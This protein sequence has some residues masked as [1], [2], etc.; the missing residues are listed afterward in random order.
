[1]KQNHK[2]I[3]KNTVMLYIRILCAM[4][5]S[6]YISRIVLQLLGVEDF[7][8]LSAVFGV[9]NLMMFVNVSLSGATSRF[10]TFELGK[11]AGGNLTKVFRSALF[12]HVIAAV[13][14]I[15]LVET[16]GLW[17]VNHKLVLGPGKLAAA[18]MLF[19]LGIGACVLSIL[20]IPYEAIVIAY[21]RMNIFAYISILQYI[22]QLALFSLLFLFPKSNLL[23]DYGVMFLL[24][25]VIVLFSYIFYD[26]KEFAETRGGPVYYKDITASIF[27][28]CM[29][30]LYSDGSHAL[31]MQG[32]NILENIFFGPVFSAATA[33]A[34]QAYLGISSFADNFL[35]ACRPQ[36]VKNYAAEEYQELQ[37]LVIN[38]T[39]L[40]L[41]LLL[42]V[43]VP[44]MI[45]TDFILRIWLKNV[46]DHA[47]V[48]CRFLLVASYCSILFRTLVFAI[49]ATGKIGK[50]S[51]GFGT[52]YLL[53]ILVSYWLLKAKAIPIIPFVVNLLSPIG[54]CIITLLLISKQIPQISVTSFLSEVIGRGGM[55]TLC[56]F[57]PAFLVQQYLAEGWIRF[58]LVMLTSTICVG[59]SGFV[60]GLSAKQRYFLI[61]YI[62]NF[63]IRFH[64]KR[65]D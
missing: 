37:F 57:I 53:V 49:Q 45:E 9:T 17:L 55:M 2:R 58:I 3:F 5:L 50:M 26:W 21:E 12:A 33:V 39:K 20:K 25:N 52:I 29:K 59:A 4:F 11:G 13:I 28:F 8:I 23:V 65:G 54:L 44:C 61:S 1:M 46:P 7:G 22:L 27:N 62:K 41:G 34:N 35:T 48:F 56:A 63:M 18:N 40:A 47:V 30:T 43:L 10:L 14:F 60:W 32:I 38:C 64:E 19:Q 16:I 31:K 15:L 42:L 36:I 24:V 51:L 6:F